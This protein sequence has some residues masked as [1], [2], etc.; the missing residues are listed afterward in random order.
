LVLNIRYSGDFSIKLYNTVSF[1]TAASDQMIRPYYFDLP[2]FLY[3]FSKINS[4]M[5]VP[6]IKYDEIVDHQDIESPNPSYGD[7]KEVEE[8]Q[9]ITASVMDLAE[10]CNYIRYYITLRSSIHNNMIFML[11]FS[12]MIGYLNS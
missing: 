10:V 7:E 9:N 6:D 11:H 12:I 3:Y 1:S 4:R 5:D 2:I 8:V